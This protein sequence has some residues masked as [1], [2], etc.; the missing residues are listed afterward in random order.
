M[1]LFS[2][3]SCFV[4]YC[5]PCEN[6]KIPIRDQRGWPLS[7]HHF[8]AG[9]TQSGH[10]DNTLSPIERSV[11]TLPKEVMLQ[12]DQPEGTSVLSMLCNP[13]VGALKC[14]VPKQ[15]ARQYL[16]YEIFLFFD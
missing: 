8:N 2:F 15:Q 7:R 4:L 1:L 12:R 10:V 5:G 13:K 6:S 11:A 14:S 16:N 3:I 9:L